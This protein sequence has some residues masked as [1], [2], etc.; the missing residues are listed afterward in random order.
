MP[1]RPL[2]P[3]EINE[4]RLVFGAGLDYSRAFVFENARW[5]NLVADLGGIWHRHKRTWN[6][7]VALGNTCYFPVRLKTSAEF[8]ANGELKDMAWL[9]HELTHQWQFQRIGWRYLTEALNVQLREGLQSYNYQKEHPSREAALLA[10]LAAGRCLAD[11]NLEQQGELARDYYY[12]L[13][14]GRAVKAWEPFVAEFR[15]G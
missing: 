15:S 3:S 14:Q 13:K 12:A 2:H 6:N 8:I 11:F 5:P 10:A 4:A 9:I 7:G 1:R